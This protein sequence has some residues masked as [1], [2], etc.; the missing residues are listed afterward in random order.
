MKKLIFL[1]AAVM[2]FG[3]A[4]AQTDNKDKSKDTEQ[5][6]MVKG[7]KTNRSSDAKT[8]DT[9]SVDTGT[10]VRSGTK[11]GARNT[12]TTSGTGNG[13]KSSGTTPPPEK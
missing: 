12:S 6:E 4:S 13:G 3:F 10:G 11:E 2:T 9:T 7:K 1:L 5:R 8:A